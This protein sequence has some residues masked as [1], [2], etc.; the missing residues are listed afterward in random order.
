M[1]TAL[2]WSGW[3]ACSWCGWMGAWCVC[4]ECIMTVCLGLFVFTHIMCPCKGWYLWE[5]FTL[6]MCLTRIIISICGVKMND[7]QVRH[8][9]GGGLT[10]VSF[11]VCSAMLSTTRVTFPF[12]VSFC[13]IYRLCKACPVMPLH[14]M[15]DFNL[16]TLDECCKL[17]GNDC[18]RPCAPP[19]MALGKLAQHTP[20]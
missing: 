18:A 6:P 5:I 14:L 16:L 19:T 13:P 9:S 3:V 4:Y 1:L 17:P 20:V 10:G 11:T 12:W 15:I 2:W 8:S 7:W